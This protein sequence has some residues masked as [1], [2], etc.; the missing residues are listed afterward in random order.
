M[1]RS[2][3]R[4]VVVVLVAVLVVA[5]AVLSG[6][7]RTGRGDGSASGAAQPPTT[8]TG[9]PAASG[10]PAGDPPVAFYNAR[11]H[12]MFPGLTSPDRTP[13]SS[14]ARP[15]GFT[16]PPPGS[17][18]QRFL[19][20]RL[21]W[22]PCG[23]F[24]C[25]TVAVPLDWDR[26]D[27]Q[28]ITLALTR[29]RATARRVGT[30]FI[31]PG[32]PGA[33]GTDF[34]GWFPRA[35]FPAFDVVGWDPRGSGRSTPVRCG[36][37]AQTDA[38]FAVDASPDTSGEWRALRSAQQAFARQCRQA[39]GVLLDH[40]STIDT[41]RDLDYLR[42]L[43]GDARLT[44]LGISY[45]TF[46]GA[47]YA[48]LYPSRV[49]RMVLDSA[50]NSTDDQSVIQP[51]GFDLALRAFASWCAGQACGLGSTGGAVVGSV[52]GL[53][54]RLDAAPLAVGARTLTQT[55]A[56]GGVASFLYAGTNGYAALAR[57]LLAARAGSGG[58]LLGA[59]DQLDGRRADGSYDPLTYAFPAIG[60]RDAGDDGWAR[61]SARWASDARLAPVF[62]RYFGPP[63]SCDVWSARPADQLDVRAQG[64]PPIVVLGTTGDPAT[65]YQQSVGMAHQL[66]SGV[67]VTWKG[68]G[69]SAFM[70]G[71]DCV[72]GTVLRYLNQGVVPRSGTTC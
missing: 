61:D 69:H 19:D 33:S 23:G 71:N 7:W 36:T 28:A 43:V 24:D 38:Y 56:V 46:I 1:R 70:L 17:G 26:P 11:D 9:T 25:A 22:H 18:M 32:G 63:V 29:G 65:P 3:R 20:Q 57:A 68:A 5:V 15:P 50:V 72:R 12:R 55:L 66:A 30:L 39:S 21:V 47:V 8:Q 16:N 51:M 58:A 13:F 37:P 6:P 4:A 10:R 62:G 41:A 27:G 44:Y 35:D 14:S 52:T 31:N 42:Y 40:I 64:A 49:G 34:V 2:A 54:D 60:C 59:A 48:E 67:L 53:F 45:G